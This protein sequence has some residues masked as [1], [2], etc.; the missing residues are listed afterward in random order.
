MV[1]AAE[2]TQAVA[3][4]LHELVTNAAKY[5]ALSTP[6]WSGVGA[7]GLAGQRKGIRQPLVLE[8]RGTGGPAIVAA[9]KAGYG[10]SVI[11]DPHSL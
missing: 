7:L 3:T 8:W 6:P 5:G 9:K 11:C 10:T 1:L 4:V 2:A